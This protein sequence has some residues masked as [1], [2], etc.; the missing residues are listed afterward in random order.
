MCKLF[1]QNSYS[2]TITF[3]TLVISFFLYI[4]LFSASL[5]QFPFPFNFFFSLYFFYS[6]SFFFS[7]F[8][9]VTWKG[10]CRPM[11]LYFLLTISNTLLRRNAHPHQTKLRCVKLY[12]SYSKKWI[13]FLHRCIH[14]PGPSSLE[15]W[16]TSSWNWLIISRCKCLE[17]FQKAPSKYLYHFI[18][19]AWECI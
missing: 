16:I 15:I 14:V 5:F 19:F 7:L 10:S 8:T 9:R 4:T 17:E 13:S 11:L 2:L 18:S 1:F 6:L 12:K 3:L